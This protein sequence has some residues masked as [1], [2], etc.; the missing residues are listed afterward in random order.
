MNVVFRVS[1]SVAGSAVAQG[2][3]RSAVAQDGEA[4]VAFLRE[5]HRTRG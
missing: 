1:G 4:L 3:A 5:F 2:V